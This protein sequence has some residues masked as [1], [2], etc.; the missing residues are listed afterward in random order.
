MSATN[1]V[2]GADKVRIGACHANR[3]CLGILAAEMVVKKHG[4]A[5]ISIVKVYDTGATC[6]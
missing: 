1:S 6:G 5:I 4:S 2:N 3:V